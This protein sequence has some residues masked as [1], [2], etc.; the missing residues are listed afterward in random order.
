MLCADEAQVPIH[1]MKEVLTTEGRNK[2]IKPKVLSAAQRLAKTAEP[3]AAGV[4]QAIAA[5]AA[6]DLL[7]IDVIDNALHQA[8]TLQASLTVQAR[9]P[10]AAGGVRPTCCCLLCCCH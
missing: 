7:S 9:I 1:I 10:E 8:H 2:E 3:G 6:G 4:V 5:L